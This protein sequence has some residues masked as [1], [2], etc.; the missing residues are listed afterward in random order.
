MP[1]ILNFLCMFFNSDSSVVVN[2][3]PKI[4]RL[5]SVPPTISNK[6]LLSSKHPEPEKATLV[7][8]ELLLPNCDCTAPI[9]WICIENLRNFGNQTVG[10]RVEAASQK[11]LIEKPK[12]YSSQ[13]ALTKSCC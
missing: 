10:A 2:K 13:R 3:L 12:R 5:I 11:T 6:G 9:F 4:T 7:L 1:Y 8:Q